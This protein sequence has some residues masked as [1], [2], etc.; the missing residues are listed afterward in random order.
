MERSEEEDQK[1]RMRGVS[2]EKEGKRQKAAR[3]G[4]NREYEAREEYKQEGRLEVEEEEDTD[5]RE[6]RTS[7]GG[8]ARVDSF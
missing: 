4:K 6:K 3:R 1:K 2:K 8:W 5:E 7:E